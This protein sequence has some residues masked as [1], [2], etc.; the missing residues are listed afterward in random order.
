MRR[1]AACVSL[2]RELSHAPPMRL[3]SRDPIGCSRAVVSAMGTSRFDA[4][5]RPRCAR[6]FSRFPAS[7]VKPV[8]PGGR[9]R[10][11]EARD[12]DRRSA[13]I[14]VDYTTCPGIDGVDSLL[15]RFAYSL[16]FFFACECVCKTA[17]LAKRASVREFK[18]VKIENRGRTE[19]LR[20]QMS[21]KRS[22]KSL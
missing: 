20:F 1:D 8:R 22:W 4:R 7:S 5:A 18:F 9:S 10:K 14:T 21:E 13:R 6:R 2:V 15:S 17:G 11:E 19:R 16:Y 3:R 12:A